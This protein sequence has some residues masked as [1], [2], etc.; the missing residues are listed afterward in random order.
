MTLNPALYSVLAVRLL[1]LS[2]FWRRMTWRC[3]ASRIAFLE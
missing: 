1:R 2:A 3:L